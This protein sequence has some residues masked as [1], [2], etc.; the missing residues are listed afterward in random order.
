MTRDLEPDAHGADGSLDAS[1]QELAR[2]LRAASQPL[3]AGM[4]A[5]RRRRQVH[6]AAATAAGRGAAPATRRERRDEAAQRSTLRGVLA[7]MRPVLAGGLALSLVAAMVA[8]VA[9]DR[10]GSPPQS[11]ALPV[12]VEEDVEIAMVAG[13]EPS[14]VPVVRSEDHVIVTVDAARAELVSAELAELLG[15][16]ATVLSVRSDRTTF[17]VPASAAAQLSEPSAVD[18]VADAPVRTLQTTR[19]IA[20]TV[21]S[22]VPSWGLDRIDADVDRLDDRYAYVSSGRGVRI[23]VIDTGVDAGHA[24]LAGRVADG[25]SA[26][27]DGRGTLDCNGHGTHVAGTAAGTEYGVAKSAV[28]V[29]V[30]VLDCSG[31]GFASSLI[32]GINWVVANHPGGPGIINLSVGGPANSAVDRAVEDAAAR[33]LLVVAAAGNDGG[34]A[35]AVSPARAASALTSGATTRN[36]VRASYSNTGGCVDLFAPGSSI[37]SAWPGGSAATL[38]GTSMAAPHVAGIAARIYQAEMTSSASKVRSLILGTAVGGAV[39][40]ADGGANLLVNLV[41]SELLE[42]DECDARIAELEEAAGPDGEVDED[43]LPEECRAFLGD[44]RDR[45]AFPGRADA[46]GGS[47]APNFGGVPPG[48]SGETPGQSGSAP[49]Q[50]GEAPGQSGS[51]PGQSGDAPGQSGSAPGQSGDAPGQSGSAPGQSGGAPGR[52]SQPA[53]DPQPEPEPD[54]GSAQSS[55]PARPAPPVTPPRGRP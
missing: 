10:I 25:W 13:F 5:E 38:S 29:P 31:A 46:P 26:I 54:S 12:E 44:E 42:L 11:D 51:A 53:P 47:R 20:A 21:Q 52:P 17:T 35:C 28:I 8:A 34:D 43:D 18:V 55:R 19:P 16:P 48:L 50:T 7:G 32:A 45:L 3:R 41:E 33:G 15:A 4:D 36:D 6:L 37:T 40:S 30:R 14:P 9:V 23:Y 49:G 22:P 24:D 27:D 2:L 1:E 39:S